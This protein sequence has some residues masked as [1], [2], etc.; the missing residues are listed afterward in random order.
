[1]P[2]DQTEVIA[3]LSD[4]ASHGGA[5]VEHVQ[6]HGA[7]VF[8]AGDH[9]YKIKRAVTYDYMDFST[10]PLREAMLRRELDLNRPMA[11]EI[12]RDICPLTRREDGGLELDG[13][14]AVV[15]WVLRMARFPREN[16]LS[17]I[18]GRGALTDG[19]AQA[20]GESIHAYHEQAPRRDADGA[21]LM[22]DIVTELEDA[23]SGMTEELGPERPLLFRQ[24]AR[25]LQAALAPLLT[26]RAAEGHVR[27]A[28]GDLHLH[29]IVL[30]DRRPVLF[31]A[32]EFDEVLGTCDVLYDLAF[33]VMD[34]RHRRLARA[35][36]IVLDSWL[37]AAE[38]QQ[39]AGLA[40]LPYFLG[41]RAA[42]KAM[43][44][45]QTGR[46]AGD[47]AE[48]AAQ[49]RGFLDD[50]LASFA[51]PPP[52]L[53]VAGG[54]SG[55]GKTTLARDLA[56]LLS[57]A[58]GA[59]HLRSDLERK[60]L[61]GVRPLDRLPADAYG[62]A[63]TQAVYD[64]LLAR[65]EALLRAG[66]SVLIDATWLA[67]A[68][69]RAVEAMATRLNLPFAALWLEAETG[70]LQARV[71]ARRGDASDADAGVVARQA[72][73]AQVPAHW[74]RIDASGRPGDTLLRAREALGL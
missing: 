37:F 2:D 55:V 47:P 1:M 36:C 50:A 31:D 71:T 51:P 33:L 10:L 7:H 32:L 44:E 72:L 38:G 69:R 40:A 66:R 74:R 54:L 6:T 3:Y 39:D 17:E 46:A 52:R 59:V 12:Y 61:A 68:E 27:R 21:R 11:P 49:A 5:P 70:T 19:L 22:A 20:L 41:I 26:A 65:A 14:G 67:P 35:A 9:A 60:R 30:L 24:R 64:R 34:L 16:E 42:I 73:H 28:H 13:R 18:A 58:P 45:V 48:H 8:L 25:R 23:F 62:A 53:L 29:N 63:A 4:P 56:P 57:P 43:V 15:E